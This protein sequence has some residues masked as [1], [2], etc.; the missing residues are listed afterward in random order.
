M[1]VTSA[2]PLV[3][4]AAWATVSS[5]P[6]AW[7][8]ARNVPVEAVQASALK[9]RAATSV[10]GRPAT[11]RPSRSRR[12]SSRRR[13]QRAMIS[14][15]PS[16]TR[17]PMGGDPEPEPDDQQRDEREPEQDRAAHH[18][19]DAQD[20][21]RERGDRHDHHGVD[22]PLDDDRAEHRRP[23][24]ALALAQGV[25]PIQLAEPRRQDVVGEVADVR[26]AEH[27]PVRQRRDRREQGPPARAARPD[28]DGRRHQH[29]ARSRP[30]TPCAG[31]RT[32]R[33][34]RPTGAG[35][36]SRRR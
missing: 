26:V 8:A 21:D 18:P 24:D 16:R 32:R 11:A 30:A 3:S 2:T 5:T 33:R 31:P 17:Q 15:D 25:A 20:E 35:S 19:A 12:A 23:A 10:P 28:V 22:D 1:I 27:P 34:G 29:H 13:G 7:P 9:A 4:S 36:R 14:A 6:T